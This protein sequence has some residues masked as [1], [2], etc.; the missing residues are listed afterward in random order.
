MSCSILFRCP[1]VKWLDF[2]DCEPVSSAPIK[3]FLTIAV[4]NFENMHLL[5]PH[6]RYKRTERH[7]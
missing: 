7:G 5:R 1:C 3:R 4:G 2:G 6:S